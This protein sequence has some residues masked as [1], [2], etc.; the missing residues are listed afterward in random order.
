MIS[1][2]SKSAAKARG[3]Y[4]RTHFKNMREVAAALTGDSLLASVWGARAN[5]ELQFQVSDWKKPTPTSRTLKS[6]N[7]LSHS[8][9]SME[10]LDERR[11]Q[12]NSKLL[13]V[14]PFQRTS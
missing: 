9:D 13:K 12:N 4:L 5:D 14:T 10:V 2:Y 6:T 7:K 3:E 1:H 11:K 8:V